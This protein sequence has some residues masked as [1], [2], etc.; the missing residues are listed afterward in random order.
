[1]SARATWATARRVLT[2]LRRD[3]RTVALIIVVPVVLLA[4]LR[5]IFDGQPETFDR[6]GG[7]LVGIFPL[8]LM[9]LVTSITMLRERTTGTLEIDGQVHE[10][11]GTGLR[12]HSWGPRYWQALHSYRWL[13]CA[14]DD[15]FSLMV[16]EVRPDEQTVNQN[17]VVIRDGTLERIVRVNLESQHEPGTLHHRSMTANVVLESGEELQVQGTV[18]GFIPLRNR[19]AGLVTH[20]GEAM[21]EYRCAGKTALGISEYLDQVQ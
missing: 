11:E 15:T 19:R 6:I 20:I 8:I 13:T 10:I 9:F 14:F 2:Q 18:K 7:P 3:P 5:F 4:L 17:G 1:M 21:T 12:D 16:S